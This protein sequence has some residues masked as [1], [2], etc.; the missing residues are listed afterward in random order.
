MFYLVYGFLYLISLL[1]FWILYGIS[2][3]AYILIYYIIGYRK[4]VVMSNIA[5]AFPEKSLAERKLIAKKFYKNF[6]DN[7]IEIIKLL[8]ISKKELQKR[9]V[10]EFDD[11][12]KYFSSGKNIQLHAGHF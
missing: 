4:E 3:L 7:F 2:Y 12:N 1:P 9:F 8:S 10:G 6:T 11:V 5:I